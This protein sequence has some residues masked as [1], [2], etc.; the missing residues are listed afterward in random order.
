QHAQIRGGPGR[1]CTGSHIR[2]WGRSDGLVA[3]VIG[4]TLG[5]V[6]SDRILHRTGDRNAARRNV[7]VAGLLGGFLFLMPVML[8][9]DVKV[10]AISLAAAFFCVEL[11]V[12][13]IWAVPMDIA[14]KYSGSASGLMNFGFG[15]AGIISPFVFGYL[16]DRTGSWTLPFAGSI[17]LLLLGAG[18]AFLM[19]PD[20]PFESA[21]TAPSAT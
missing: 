8:I 1:S 10:A 5:G 16:I 14:Q 9:N 17:G 2:T 13:P 7:I 12:A 15:V 4:D 21:T 20:R 11:V 18:L 6:V 3:G 19:R